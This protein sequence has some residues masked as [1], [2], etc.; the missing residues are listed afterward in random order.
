MQ[1]YLI[2]I[3]FGFICLIFSCGKKTDPTPLDNN[4]G[5]TTG[6]TPGTTTGTT[7]GTTGG[8]TNNYVVKTIGISRIRLAFDNNNNI[9]VAELLGG[10]NRVIVRTGSGNH[11][12]LVN[13]TGGEPYID[14]ADGS[15]PN[16]TYYA[17]PVA[18]N[19]TVP[20]DTLHT[21]VIKLTGFD[22]AKVGYNQLNLVV[23]KEVRPKTIEFYSTMRI[24]KMNKTKPNASYNDAFF[25][26][27]FN[28]NINVTSVEIAQSADPYI[29]RD[30]ITDGV[31]I[32][33]DKKNINNTI[34]LKFYD[35]GLGTLK[36]WQTANDAFYAGN[37]IKTK[38]ENLDKGNLT[39]YKDNYYGFYQPLLSNIKRGDFDQIV[40]PADTVNKVFIRITGFDKAV[41]GFNQLRLFVTELPPDV[42]NPILFYLNEPDKSVMT[43]PFI[44][45]SFITNGFVCDQMLML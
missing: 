41:C 21:A 32:V 2:F 40:D 6:T 15:P 39:Y 1:R 22:K 34:S 33:Y 42:N 19:N 30:A 28:T 14:V 31:Q 12:E 9:T 16:A 5:T 25:K 36:L 8:T 23:C 7:P 45:Q 24:L 29:T 38:I 18:I 26:A 3:C 37:P 13:N 4:T 20:P 35:N 11:M 27:A 44:Q 10:G 17:S 43:I